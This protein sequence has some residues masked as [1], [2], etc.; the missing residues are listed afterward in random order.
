MLRT[1]GIKF[2]EVDIIGTADSIEAA[3]KF[4]AGEVD[5]AITWAPLDQE[6]VRA[7]R[8]SHVLTSTK[9]AQ[10]IIADVF[11]ASEDVLRTN[12]EDIVKIV[13]GWLIAQD[14][15]TNFEEA[16]EEAAG[17][18]EDATGSAYEDCLLAV[19]DYV[20][21]TN[22]E[23]NK[24]FFGTDSDYP[25]GE[26]L[27]SKMAKL[28]HKVAPD[29]VADRVPAFKSLVDKRVLKEVNITSQTAERKIEYTATTNEE[30]E[31]EALASKKSFNYFPNGFVN[32]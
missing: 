22:Y 6:C 7:V 2:S 4:K 27:Y 8:G 16:R 15:L 19:G 3:E 21:F 31:R 28:Y 24:L 30:V 12:R 13:E 23:D 26:W 5:A 18:M 1:A 9:E 29:L 17:Y 11:F 14:E 25:T 10:N 32:S 20:Y